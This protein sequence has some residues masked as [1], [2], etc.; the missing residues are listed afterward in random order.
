VDKKIF[1]E[2]YRMNEKQLQLLEWVGKLKNTDKLIVVEGVKDKRALE[3]FGI[4][5]IITLKKAIYKTAEDIAKQEK[6]CIILTDLDREGKKLYKELST[7]LQD[8]GV[9][10]DKSF[11]EFLFRKTKLRQIEGLRKYLEK[12]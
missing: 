12:L 11:R 4:E 8:L 3:K 2:V 5:D 6:D 1:D 7:K 9:K 10:V